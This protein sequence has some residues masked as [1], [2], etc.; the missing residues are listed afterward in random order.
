MRLQV[1]VFVI[2][3]SSLI[4]SAQTSPENLPKSTDLQAIELT[5]SDFIEGLNTADIDRYLG[6][7]APDVSVFLARPRSPA[8]VVGISKIKEVYEPFFIRARG[9]SP[10]PRYMNLSPKDLE[11]I[12]L[13][14]TAIVTFHLGELKQSPTSPYFFSRR[15]LIM[16]KKS[17]RWIIVHLHAS[18]IL[19]KPESAD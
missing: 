4:S 13:G 16:A 17:E 15:T 19:V 6:T 7:F 12:I 3:M 2:L 18:Q 8:R 9:N 5:L 10:G 14:S 11:V 1:V